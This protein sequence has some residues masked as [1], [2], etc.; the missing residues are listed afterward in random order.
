MANI[1]ARKDENGNVISYRIRVHK[2][3]DQYGKQLKPYEMTWKPSPTMTPKQAEKELNR[4]TTLFEEKCKLGQVCDTKQ[5]FAQYA[6]YV[7]GLKKR[8]GVKRKTLERYNDFLIRINQG[9]G[10]LKIQDIKPQH[11]NKLY[12]QLAQEGIRKN[13]ERA[14]CYI[15]LTATLKAMGLTK[16]RLHEHSKVALVTI[17]KACRCEPIMLEKAKSISN[18]LQTPLEEMFKIEKDNTPLSNKTI[19]EHH[20]LISTILEQADKE[21]LIPFNPARKASPPKAEKTQANYF[22]IEDVER[23][24]DALEQE[25]LKWKTLVH[26]LLITGA[27]R[28][29]ILGLKWSTVDFKNNQIHICCDLL[30]SREIGIYEDSTKNTESDRFVN[31]PAETMD[32]LKE[33]K[34]WYDSQAKIYGDRWHDTGYLFFQ[35]KSGNEGKPMHPDSVNGWL[36]DFSA[37]YELPHINPHAFRHTMASI[38]YFNGADSI[39]ISKRLGHA[40]VSTTVNLFYGHTGQSSLYSMKKPHPLMINREGV[41]MLFFN[42]LGFQV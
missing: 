6:D 28:A 7:I 15:D 10:H 25:P 12:E 22:E 2:G 29:E 14:I 19:L 20:R 26:M 11:L 16:Q 5:T 34:S 42:F 9:I 33:Y 23:I 30:Y 21:M 32:L 36:D 41:A 35:E 40:K 24:R 38:L 17:N 13:T 8:L 4:Q 39:S 31:L 37:R 1:T 3:R 27:R 18:T